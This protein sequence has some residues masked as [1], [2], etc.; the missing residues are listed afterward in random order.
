MNFVGKMLRGMANKLAPEEGENQEHL[1]AL[2]VH[3]FAEPASRSVDGIRLD[4]SSFP[5]L[6]HR[7][8]P[9]WDRFVEDKALLVDRAFEAVKPYYDHLISLEGMRDNLE[10]Q[11]V[12]KGIILRYIEWFWDLKSSKNYHHSRPWEGLI[13]SLDTSCREAE[14][15]L[16]NPIYG[17]SGID[18]ERS[19][20]DKC[21]QV[22]AGFLVGI[23]HDVG[24]LFDISIWAEADGKKIPYEPLRGPL[25]QFKLKYPPLSMN[26][27]EEWSR[28]NGE[29]KP[30]FNM[31]F[32][33]TIVPIKV[34]Q[35]MPHDLMIA[36]MKKL[37]SYESLKSDRDSVHKWVKQDSEG[38]FDNLS[39]SIGEW[40]NQKPV[41]FAQNRDSCFWKID[42]NWYFVAEPLFFSILAQRTALD[43]ATLIKTLMQKGYL[44]STSDGHYYRNVPLLWGER[45]R[46]VKGSFLRAE[47]IDSGVS[48][49]RVES[50]GGGLE[51]VK[52]LKIHASAKPQVM[53]LFE[54]VSEGLL[55]GDVFA[56][57][58][59]HGQQVPDVVSK[60][61]SKDSSETSQADNS[62]ES[63]L[64]DV[65]GGEVS[66]PSDGPLDDISNFMPEGAVTDLD[67]EQSEATDDTPSPT[68]DNIDPVTGEVLDADN[69]VEED[70]PG[71]EA[72]S[73]NED[74]PEGEGQDPDVPTPQK[75]KPD[76]TSKV[77]PE[78]KRKQSLSV[79][80]DLVD[81]EKKGDSPLFTR[82][83][84]ASAEEINKA[85]GQFADRVGRGRLP[86]QLDS[87]PMVIVDNFSQTYIQYPHA[88]NVILGFNA[89]PTNGMKNTRKKFLTTLEQMGLIKRHNGELF[90]Q[91]RIELRGSAEDEDGPYLKAGE[92]V[93]QFCLVDS[94]LLTQKS[95]ALKAQILNQKRLNNFVTQ[96]GEM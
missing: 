47:V 82:V 49:V 51:K 28:E 96:N 86:F 78:E 3:V 75:G 56:E 87:D 6:D 25:L 40:Y 84:E 34:Y 68:E 80:A 21:W 32:A 65:L 43:S 48:K 27:Q 92:V 8:K 30:F 66:S 89:K 50:G 29:M 60:D 11:R 9:S 93:G 94:A 44:P 79:E 7:E 52:K 19:R 72:E 77:T 33:W 67:P 38:F 2:D 15:F 55:R 85:I 37:L 24:K 73:G 4:F 71:E 62:S 31:M 5:V 61:P 23:L 18:G 58:G 42:P 22:F 16:A 36:A 76:K 46:T 20:K 91:M 13:H 95:K 74:V 17:R 26:V 14:V 35:Q 41:D 81:E 1:D 12:M 59:E 10:L 63:D 57:V 90:S 69:S 54:N 70:V 39:R 83:N 64:P 88:L 53:H 45:E